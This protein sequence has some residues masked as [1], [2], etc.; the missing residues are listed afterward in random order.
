MGS[1]WLRICK[2]VLL[3]HALASDFSR[4][5]FVIQKGIESEVSK[6]VILR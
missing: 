5:Q 1:R 6:V 3:P 4:P 2:A